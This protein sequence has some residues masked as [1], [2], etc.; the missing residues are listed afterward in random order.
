MQHDAVDVD[1]VFLTK[2]N[3]IHKESRDDA[4]LGE[5]VVLAVFSLS[6]CA[7]RLFATKTLA[8][9]ESRQ[10]DDCCKRL[11]DRLPIDELI[12]KVYLIGMGF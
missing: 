2:Q 4:D 1:K 12:L 10:L 7:P 5:S 3:E 11:I 9:S 8:G 6:L